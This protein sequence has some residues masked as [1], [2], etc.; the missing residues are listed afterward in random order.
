MKLYYCPYFNGS[1]ELWEHPLHQEIVYIPPQRVLE[2]TKTLHE[3]HTYWDCPAWRSYWNNSF[4]IFN[5]LDMEFE[6]DKEICKITKKSFKDPKTDYIKIQEMT[7]D[8]M[9]FELTQQLLVWLP[10]KEKNVWAEVLPF[11]RMFHKTGLEYLSSEFPVSRWHK[12]MVPIYKA[13]A[14]KIKLKRGDPLYT[15]RFKGG[16]NNQYNLQPWKDLDPP[17]WL[18]T[19]FIQHNN[20][21]RWVTGGVWNLFRRDT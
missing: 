5:Q 14:S 7:K 4:V 2:Y 9:I 8:G 19:K 17:E 1:Q 13:H 11:P 18:K 6:W 10:N 3:G 20:M 16:K 15:I 21:G 12:P